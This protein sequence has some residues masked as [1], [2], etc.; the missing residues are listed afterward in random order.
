MFY[1]RKDNEII[2][3]AIDIMGDN[4][5]FVVTD[6]GILTDDGYT[7][8]NAVMNEEYQRWGNGDSV[9]VIVDQY[10]CGL[11]N[12]EI[13]CRIYNNDLDSAVMKMIQAITAVE[14][15]LYFSITGRKRRK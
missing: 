14:S 3:E 11:F 10:G 4:I 6:D 12:K 13:V 1:E 9:G 15:H 7:Y 2:T 8:R 5:S